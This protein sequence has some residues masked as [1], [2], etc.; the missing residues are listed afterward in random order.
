MQQITAVFTHLSTLGGKLEA[1]DE[2]I[3]SIMDSWLLLRDIEHEGHRS[4]ALFVLKSRGM[5]HS[6]EMREFLLTDD[7][8]R[9]GGVYTDMLNSARK[10]PA[11]KKAAAKSA[12][13]GKGGKNAR[14]R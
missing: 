7:G 8:I 9:L 5:A 11:I 2:S 13:V 4:C 14:K 6:R 10:H 1:T 12:A 3:S